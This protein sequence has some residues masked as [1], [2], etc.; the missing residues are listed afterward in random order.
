MSQASSSSGLIKVDKKAHEIYQPISEDELADAVASLSGQLYYPLGSP[1]D[2]RDWIYYG[3]VIET[4]P[5]HSIEVFITKVDGGFLIGRSTAHKTPAGYFI[6]N[7]SVANSKK[8]EI[9]VKDMNE[10]I[11]LFNKLRTAKSGGKRRHHK[12]TRRN[13]KRRTTRRR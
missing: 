12:Q 2:R 3:K 1:G 9:L 5:V 10:A 13:R 11:A 7:K 8:D 4:E 6:L